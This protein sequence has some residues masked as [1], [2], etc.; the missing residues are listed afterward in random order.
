[1]RRLDLTFSA[2]LLPLDFLALLAAAATAYALRFSKTFVEIRPLLQDLPFPQYLATA[3]FFAVI[4][5]V[6][7]AIAGLY[8]MRHRKIVNELG[9]VILASTAGIMVVIATVFFRREF[10]TSRFIV[11]AFWGLA[12]F[13]VW[14][15][16]LILRTMRHELLRARVGHQRLVLVGQDE[17]AQHLRELYRTRPILGFTVVK[18]YKIWQDAAAREIAKLREQNL[19]D[20]IL[21][22]DPAMPKDES[23]NLIAFAEDNH[24]TFR[25]LADPFAARFTNIE[26][27]TSEGIPIIEVKRTP[28]DGWGR[29][30]KRAFDIVFSLIIL[31]L[32]SPVLLVTMLV[33][34]LEDGL[35]VIFQ[36]V[37]VGERGVSFKTYKL[38]SMW[39]RFCIGPQFEGANK[40]NLE[41]EANLIKQKSIKEGPLYKIAGDPRVTPIGHFIRRWSIDEL[42]QF[43]NVLIGNMSIIGPRPHQPRE[44][45]KYLPHQRRVLAIKPGIT[46][47]A[48][49][50]GRSDLTFEEEANLDVWYIEHWSLA[51]D[52]TILLKTPSAALNKKGAY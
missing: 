26:V 51:L 23:L 3:A 43:W 22:A 19:V 5:L 30:I 48:Q 37:R 21:L 34:I 2:L 49:V 41:L 11:L 29:I 36:N 38:R 50:S 18:T 20:G 6:I 17:A 7:F 32:V 13:Y 35:P 27:S 46:G 31:I 12:I 25:Y 1:M 14:I 33:L 47:M 10:T 45:A 40:K 9:R 28:L 24:L 39:R 16:R 4:W 15:F 42:P 8:T 44:V 52:L